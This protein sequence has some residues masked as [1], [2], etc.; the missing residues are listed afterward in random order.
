[1]TKKL[2]I[3]PSGEVGFVDGCLMAVVYPMPDCP[4]SAAE[5]NFNV[6]RMIECWNYFDALISLNAELL[7]ALESICAMQ[8]RNYGDATQTHLDLPEL[9]GKARELIAKA[10]SQA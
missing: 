8:A 3:H 9:T 7:E 6:A 2:E 10:R 4:Q 5:R 1:M